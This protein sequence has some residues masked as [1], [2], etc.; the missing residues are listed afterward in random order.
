MKACEPVGA[1]DERFM[2]PG[3][4]GRA[5]VEDEGGACSWSGKDFFWKWRSRALPGWVRGWM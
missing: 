4:S 2:A 1:T 5:G 3:G